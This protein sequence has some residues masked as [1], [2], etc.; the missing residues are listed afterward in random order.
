MI[1]RQSVVPAAD[2]QFAA[3]MSANQ[4]TAVQELRC[5]DLCPKCQAAQMDYNGLLNLAC[6]LCG[7][8][9]GGCFT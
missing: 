3:D 7:Y 9:L 8:S 5:G 4:P 1:E 6:P 2:I